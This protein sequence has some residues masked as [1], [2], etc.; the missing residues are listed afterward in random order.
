M[1]SRPVSS[2]AR[3]PDS[4]TPSRWRSSASPPAL[5]DQGWCTG[6]HRVFGILGHPMRR[7]MIRQL[8]RG[9]C[10][11]GDLARD[12]AVTRPAVSQHLRLMLQVGVVTE[13][14]H[15]RERRYRLE[16]AALEDVR[17]FLAGLDT[18]WSGRLNAL[19]QLLQEQD[20]PGLQE[21][22]VLERTR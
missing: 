19:G 3:S 22:D 4:T 2:R 7:T 17:V 16:P 11:V 8:A 1:K 12:Q 13:R 5:R 20:A 21:Q 14:R 18:F 9:E 6:A 10:S 15:G